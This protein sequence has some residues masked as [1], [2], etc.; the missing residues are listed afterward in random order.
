VQIRIGIGNDLHRLVEGR[1]LYLG[2]I[3]IPHHL[4]LF[5][6]SDGD[7]AIHAL[8]DALLGASGLGDIGRHFPDTDSQYAGVSSNLLLEKTRDLIKDAGFSII[9]LDGIIMAQQPK[10]NTFFPVMKEHL[11][12]ILGI[13]SQLINLKAK[14][15]E[16]L[17]EIGRSEA[18]S[19]LFV[20]L[21]HQ[22]L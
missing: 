9:N 15:G 16:G 1:P 3:E 12:E 18:I 17:G 13:S 8:I 7:A 22:E 19:A 5:G 11:A 4:G 21:L 10:L 2:G 20:V 14:T 6:H